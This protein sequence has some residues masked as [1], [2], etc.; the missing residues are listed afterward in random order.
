VWVFAKILQN[1]LSIG[2]KWCKTLLNFVRFKKME[3]V[4]GVELSAWLAFQAGHVSSI[5]I[6][7]LK[8]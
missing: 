8:S 1:W 2:V 3:A 5:L 4:L 7:R 6:T